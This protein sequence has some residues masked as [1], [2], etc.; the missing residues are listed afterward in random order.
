MSQG[1]IERVLFDGRSIIADRRRRLRGSEAVDAA[2]VEVDP[3]DLEA[4]RFCA[5]GAFIRAAYDLVGDREVAQ[6]LGWEA[7]AQVAEGANLRRI[8]E[9]EPGWALA[10]LSD[11]RGQA[12]VLRVLDATLALRCA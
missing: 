3:C 8:D 10:K 5:V 7:A 6:R 1:L 2:G 4:R 9:D 11:S 12:A